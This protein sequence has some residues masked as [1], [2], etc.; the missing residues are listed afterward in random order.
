MHDFDH[1]EI[2]GRVRLGD[3]Q[4]RIGDDLG[5]LVGHLALSKTLVWTRTSTCSFVRKDV[6]ATLHS[7][8]LSCSTL[9]LLTCEMTLYSPSSYLDVVQ[10]L[11]GLDL[12]Q[13]KALRDESR[14]HALGKE[15]LGLL[16]QFPCK[17]HTGSRSIT[18]LIT[19]AGH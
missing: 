18:L 5:Q 16:E 2:D 8:S 15:S 4:N 13:I 17:E 11:G 3:R 14:V 19:K 9:S 1:M 6:L 10:N 7:S 12:R